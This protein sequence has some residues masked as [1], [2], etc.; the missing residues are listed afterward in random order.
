MNIFFRFQTFIINHITDYVN[1]T[2]YI[3]DIIINTDIKLLK[4]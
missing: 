1:K 2:F 3:V 4:S